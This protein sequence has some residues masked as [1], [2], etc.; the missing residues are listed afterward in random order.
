MRLTLTS[1]FDTFPQWKRTV[2]VMIVA[3]LFSATGFSVIFPFFPLYVEQLGTNTPLS[4]EFL[5]GLVFSIQGISMMIAAPIWGTLADRYG[6]K[7]MIMRAMFGGTILMALMAFVRTAEELVI[8][9]GLQ[10]AVTGTVSAIDS[11]AAAV[12]PREHV[13]A[14]MGII[15]AAFWGGLSLGPLIGGVL[16][17]AFGYAMPFL[18]TSVLLAIAGV[19]ILLFVEEVRIPAEKQR[20]NSILTDWRRILSRPGIVW[21]YGSRFLGHL[22]RTLVIPFAPLFVV[23]LLPEGSNTEATYTGIMVAISALTGAVSA[24]YLGRL[25]DRVGHRVILLVSG[26]FGC[27]IYFGEALVTNAYQLIALQALT[28]LAIG[29]TIASVSALLATYSDPTEAGAVYGLNSSV[30][31]G[32]T[33]IAPLIGALFAVQFG[34]RSTFVAAAVMFALV[35]VIAVYRLPETHHENQRSPS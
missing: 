2:A 25:G 6:Y 33:S 19:L 4:I 26:V 1:H 34:I 21:V 14:T 18:V 8:L 9:R 20:R 22:A 13:G 24:Y 23:T 17:D 15:Q 28:G 27:V 12:V 31:S 3:Q 16:A 5:A 10:G 7:L 32:A 30:V 29:G 11:L 35:A